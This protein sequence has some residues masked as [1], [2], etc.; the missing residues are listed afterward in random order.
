MGKN[1]G[2]STGAVALALI[3][4]GIGAA[5]DFAGVDH[6][7]EAFTA[8]LFGDGKGFG[9]PAASKPFANFTTFYPYY[10]SL[11]QDPTNRL[12]HLA[13]STVLCITVLSAPSILVAVGA[14]AA[15]GRCVF[16]LVRHMPNGAVELAV[17]VFV[18]LATVKA[19]GGGLMKRAML[20]MTISYTFAWIGHFMF[21]ANE[22]LTFIYPSFSLVA[23]LVLSFDVAKELVTQHLL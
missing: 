18:F 1:E 20:S 10:V 17:M 4:I 23:D 19:I 12:L 6:D 3:A 15:A 13:A 5:V 11:H 8:S 21:E 16:P 2:I 7:A 22:P 9:P 14:A